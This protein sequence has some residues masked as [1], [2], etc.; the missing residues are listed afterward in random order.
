MPLITLTQ[1]ERDVAGW[2]A[3]SPAEAEPGS[4]PKLMYNVNLPPV[5]VR[6]AEAEGKLGEAWRALNVVPLPDV[7][8]VS[9]NTTSDTVAATAETASFHVT[10]T[11]PGISGTWTA[12]E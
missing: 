7:P 9:L 5:V 11:G 3:T 12:E 2:L 8:T 1:T 10:I 6:D 4:Y